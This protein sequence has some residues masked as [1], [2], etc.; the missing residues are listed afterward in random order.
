[1]RTTQ[2]STFLTH[3]ALAVFAV[4]TAA[5]TAVAPPA[6]A[7]AQDVSPSPQPRQDAPA[8]D[9]PQPSP[10]A[11]ALADLRDALHGDR[12]A[13][14]EGVLALAESAQEVAETI[15]GGLP[16]PMTTAGWRVLRAR[17]DNGTPRP[18]HL[19][20]PESVAASAAPAPL[21]I[22]M[23]GGVSRPEF[24]DDASFEGRRTM[25]QEMAD[26]QGFVLACPLARADCTWWS[27]AG[28]GH[29]RAVVRYAKRHAPID[30]DRVVAAGFSDGASG[31]YYLAMAAPDPFAAL[32]PMN[33]HP[34]VATGASG[35]QLY[36]RN[37]LSMPLFVCMTQD[38]GLYPAQTVLPHIQALIREGASLHVVSYPTGGHSPSY[39]A[40]QAAALGGFVAGAVRDPL[41]DRIE[42]ATAHEETG[43]RAWMEILEIRAG[44][45]DAPAAD[46][47][48]MQ[49][50]S[51]PGRVLIGIGV[52]RE[53]AGAGVRVTT[54]DED[55]PAGPLGIE[56]GDVVVAVDGAPVA[57]LADLRRV[58][59]GKRFGDALA[60]RVER[61]GLDAPL[62]LSTT[63]APFT[64]EPTYGRERPTAW[65]ALTRDGNTVRVTSRGVGRFRLQLSDAQFDLGAEVVVIVNGVER[66]RA[67]PAPDVRRVVEGWAASAD[68][69]LSFA[70]F[71]DVTVPP[72]PAETK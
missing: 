27:D 68:S 45:G 30:S 21:L 62:D 16:A 49:V 39:L 63:I 38:D 34:L 66:A 37:A 56:V 42:W 53:Y 65:I 12:S 26:A 24:I 25:W 3:T 50:M 31:C 11:R 46:V 35:R 29:V 52:D 1:M 13:A 17:D 69:G 5:A 67:V 60:V 41:P 48:D 19:Y 10:L 47:P 51:T 44:A 64:S 14:I 15:R 58:L 70:A 28:V 20:V 8:E 33:G 22:D 9:A 57:N 32:V 7:L 23:H 6:S 72:V 36:L 18:Y 43:A 61:D 4:L 40:D 55:R 59:G 54:V 71:L 2:T